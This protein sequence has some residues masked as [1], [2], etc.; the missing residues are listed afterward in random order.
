MDEERAII[1]TLDFFTPVVDDPYTF[2]QIA[3]AN[4]LSDIYAMGGTP[5]TAMNIVCFPY[6]VPSSILRDILK[7][8]SYKIYEAGTLVVG[9]HIV[10]DMEPKYGLS[11]TGLI[12]PQEIRANSHAKEGDILFL[13]KPIGLG[14]INTAIKA[15]L[16]SKETMEQ[17]VAIMTYLNRDARDAMQ[18][19]GVNGCTDITGFGLLGHAYEMAKASNVTI[20]IESKKVPIIEEAIELGE[21]GLV[22]GGAYS[23]KG[24]IEDKITWLKDIPEIYKDLLFDPQTSGG[25]LISVKEEKADALKLLLDRKV[26]TSFGVIGRVLP[27]GNNP[28][29]VK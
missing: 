7:G 10:D 4:S 28:L 1:Q 17:A 19:I 5:L 11:V 24:F 13:T 16:V 15:E 26:K 18:E 21:M 27:K 22:P 9:G 29:M 25:L 20:E 6:C 23:N 2:G 14:I 12:H 3:A 8:G